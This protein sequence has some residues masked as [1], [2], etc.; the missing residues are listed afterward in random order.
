MKFLLILFMLL[1]IGVVIYFIVKGI[2]D[3]LRTRKKLKDPDR[4]MFEFLAIM[5]IIPPILY[6]MDRYNIFSIF[7]LTKNLTSNYDWLAFIGSY[8]STVSSALLLI[9][10]TRK[11]REDSNENV[12]ESQRPSLCTRVYL[13][14]NFRITDTS[15]EG[16]ICQDSGKPNSSSQYIIRI[17]NSGQTAAIID[18]DKSY[19]RA[20]KYKDE[21]IPK[22]KQTIE[23]DTLLKEEKVFFSKYEDRLQI[24]PN[25][26]ADIVIIDEGM[27]R[28]ISS[29]ERPCI[30]VV[31]IEYSDLFGKKYK[32][33]IR[34]VD[35][36]TKVISDNELIQK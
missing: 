35:G 6:Y 1:P 24:S 28:N 14:N 12:R 11:D 29:A 34:V 7:K 4:A 3:Y 27:H 33:H 10:V 20:K 2:V 8:I 5:L 36:K 18:T 23:I 9:Y 19:F 21:V 17:N 32:D 31:Y 16:Y 22:S 30:E 13:P 26:K 15:V 25:N